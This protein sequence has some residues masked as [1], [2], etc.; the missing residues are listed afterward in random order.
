MKAI[1]SALFFALVATVM[2]AAQHQPYFIT[3]PTPGEAVKAGTPFDLVWLNGDDQEVVIHLLQGNG[4]E[5]MLPTGTSVKTQG[6]DG[7]VKFEIPANSDPKGNY[8]F[9]ID[10]V[11][12][13]GRNAHAF[14]MAFPLEAGS[15]TTPEPSKSSSSEET[16]ESTPATKEDDKKEETEKKEDAE[17]KEETEKKE[18]AD[19]KQEAE[20]KEEADKTEEKKEQESTPA[21]ATPESQEG[22]DEDAESAAVTFKFAATMMAV[23][24]IVAGAF[25]A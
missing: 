11:S 25:L 1:L 22:D 23:P 24:A 14:S 2:V 19:K 18:D 13:K 20:K 21:T 3:S 12:N 10:Y 8:A 15:A 5:S 16:K 6:S 4:R 7:K 9:R 17:K